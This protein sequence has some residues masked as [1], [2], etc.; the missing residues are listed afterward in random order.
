MA[1]YSILHQK[2]IQEITSYYDLTVS[3]FEA[4]DGGQGNSSYLLTSNRGDYVLTVFD[5]KEWADVIMLGQLLNNLEK[6]EFNT[7]RIIPRLD[8][9]NVTK[10]QKKPVMIKPYI[11]GQVIENLNEEMLE[12]SGEEI[13]KLHQIPPPDYLPLTQSYGRQ[14]FSNVIGKGIDPDY[15]SWLANRQKYLENHFPNELP[16]GLIHGD[17]YYDNLLFD[18]NKLQAIIDFEE[19]CNYYLIFDIGMG[20]VGQCT[21]GKTV[22]LDKARALVTGYQKVRK[23][24]EAERKALQ[25]FVEYAAIA[26]SY[27]FFWN[28]HIFL[29]TPDMQKE[30]C[31]LMEI[32][33]AVNAIPKADFH[34]AVFE[35]I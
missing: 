7:T 35:T 10:Y 13:A 16:R 11:E 31:K 27:W 5:G 22:S 23:L 8:G 9:E 21:D 32:A 24:A 12:Q 30:H 28:Y 3:H 6:N 14:V 18:K 29:P 20:I 2:D 4:I 15:E 25:V 33:D 26:T 1:R 34:K 17:L 19:A